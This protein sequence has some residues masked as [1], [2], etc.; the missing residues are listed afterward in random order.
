MVHDGQVFST[1][2]CTDLH[3]KH[4]EAINDLVESFQMYS[5]HILNHP[6]VTA[7]CRSK[8]SEQPLYYEKIIRNI[9]IVLQMNQV[10]HICEGLPHVPSP[11]YVLSRNELENDNIRFILQ[12][13]QGNADISDKETQTIHMEFIRERD[14]KVHC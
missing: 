4:T 6:K 1:E 2:Y 8:Q 3:F 9:N 7:D 12:S 13:A 10:C 11:R 5:T 14:S